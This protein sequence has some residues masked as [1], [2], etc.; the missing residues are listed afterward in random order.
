M[1]QTP[2]KDSFELALDEKKRILQECQ[3]TKNTNSCYNCEKF[4]IALREMSMSKPCMQV[5]QRAQMTAASSF[6]H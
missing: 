2:Q 6:R 5:C 1:S 4:L 3:S